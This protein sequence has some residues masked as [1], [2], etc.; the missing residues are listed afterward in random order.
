[1]VDDRWHLTMKQMK[2]E[3]ISGLMVPK[4][5]DK[6]ATLLRDW[7]RYTHTCKIPQEGNFAHDKV[8]WLFFTSWKYQVGTLRMHPVLPGQRHAKVYT[9]IWLSYASICVHLYVN[10]HIYIY[11]EIYINIFIYVQILI[12]KSTIRACVHIH[13]YVLCIIYRCTYVIILANTNTCTG[14]G[15]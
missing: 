14:P 12:Y 2:L 10:M 3:R 7:N 6:A 4:H 5:F 11:I 13:T 8:P 9:Y 15:T 1:M